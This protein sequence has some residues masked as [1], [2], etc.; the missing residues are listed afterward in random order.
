M[1][2]EINERLRLAW[3]SGPS[4]A[5]KPQE[6][7]QRSE[8]CADEL[9]ALHAEV[10]QGI[11]EIRAQLSK[12]ADR[13]SVRTM[14][15][16]AE[17]EFHHS[18]QVSPVRTPTEVGMLAHSVLAQRNESDL[19]IRQGA[20]S[21]VGHL[22]QACKSLSSRKE[23]GDQG[24]DV[25]MS[26]ATELGALL[27]EVDRNCHAMAL[28]LDDMDGGLAEGWVELLCLAAS[29]GAAGDLPA[30]SLACLE[31][32]LSLENDMLRAALKRSRAAP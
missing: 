16:E 19:P 23:G 18:R 32:Q 1:A 7:A 8:H 24:S 26:I 13:T 12:E 6:L 20:G 3:H 21:D 31:V 25:A 27:E 4:H 15:M 2:S 17:L 22:L 10:H 11:S 14:C 28:A 29:H 30:P 5:S 9:S